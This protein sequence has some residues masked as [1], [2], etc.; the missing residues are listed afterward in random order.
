MKDQNGPKMASGGLK[1]KVTFCPYLGGFR[2]HV[3]MNFQAADQKSCASGGSHVLSKGDRCTV[4][5]CIYLCFY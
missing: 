2:F 4:Q 1:A 3:L 5:H